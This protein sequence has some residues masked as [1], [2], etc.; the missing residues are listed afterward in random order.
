MTKVYLAILTSLFFQLISAQKIN[1]TVQDEK[2]VSLAGVVIETTSSKKSTVSDLDG[3]FSIELSINDKISFSYLGYKSLILEGTSNMKVVLSEVISTLS[4]VVVVGYGTKK[5][6]VIT[7]SVSQVK[8][9]DIIKTPSQSAIQAIQGKAAGINIVTNDEPG[10]NPSIRIRGL[11][12]L[13]GGRDPLFL[14]Y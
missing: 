9:A 5:A 6:G 10:A 11:G 4:D 3:N 14:S 7:G 8:A 2:G 1:G 13:L 12:T